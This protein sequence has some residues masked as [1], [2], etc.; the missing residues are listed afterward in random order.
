MERIF[1]QLAG[2]GSNV[3]GGGVVLLQTSLPPVPEYLLWV[4]NQMQLTD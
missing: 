1:I 3:T 2:D 4:A